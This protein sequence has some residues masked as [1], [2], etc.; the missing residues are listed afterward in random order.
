MIYA[1][2][3]SIGFLVLWAFCL[4][5][6]LRNPKLYRVFG[7]PVILVKGLWILFFATLSPFVLV[8]YFLLGFVVK[9]NDERRI[10]AHIFY[11][12]LFLLGAAVSIPSLPVE[13]PTP[14]H[15]SRASSGWQESND[16]PEKKTVPITSFIPKFHL[17]VIESRNNTQTTSTV[18]AGSHASIPMQ[19]VAIVL[20][21]NHPLLSE[22]AQ[23]LKD[24]LK[25][26]PDV[27]SVDIWPKGEN[28]PS[29]GLLPDVWIRL[30]MPKISE[31]R[32]FPTLQLNTEITMTASNEPFHSSHSYQE[33]FSRPAI[34]Y[35][36]NCDLSH[37][38][39][40]VSINSASE[41]YALATPEIGKE[42]VSALRDFLDKNKAQYGSAP[43]E[44]ERFLP[45]RISEY[46][47]PLDNLKN[48]KP[49]I[50]G[51]LPLASNIAYWEIPV[52]NDLKTDFNRMA[53]SLKQ[54]GWH[55]QSNY[56]ENETPYL[57]YAQG[58]DRLTAFLAQDLGANLENQ[59][60]SK[61]YIVKLER[62]MNSDRVKSI[63][64]QIAA[65][66][67]SVDFLLMM[68]AWFYQD[69]EMRQVYLKGLENCQETRPEILLQ[70]SYLYGAM[71]DYAKQWRS[72]HEA[73]AAEQW[74]GGE[75][76]QKNSIDNEIEK[77]QKDHSDLAVDVSWKE[78]FESLGAQEIK[79]DKEIVIERTIKL[80]EPVGG[81]RLDENGKPITA[82]AVM[83]MSADKNN[84]AP[85]VLR[86]RNQSATGGSGTMTGGNLINNTPEKYVWNCNL[87]DNNISYKVTCETGV[88][89]TFNLQLIIRLNR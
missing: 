47:V 67:C 41:K 82:C 66:G 79:G 56:G 8:E 77:F 3:L 22:I 63:L 12:L 16:V 58:D 14:V 37:T 84:L 57:R 89:D 76:S 39:K 15:V 9:P 34:D 35:N 26:I 52:E 30:E 29:G 62:G 24:S 32:L 74:I 1:W 72:L 64:R 11:A 5:H 19:R 61:T 38:S 20:G 83:E 49:S 7:L 2:A 69:E 28:P 21:L 60:Q 6:C 13:N 46:Q 36:L 50:Q 17:G 65:E 81:Y 54:A 27:K 40:T 70:K 48:I 53:E 45:E 86:V 71:G 85:Y 25:E 33:T 31:M 51:Y 68:N 55:E 43:A 42:L 10:P 44:M 4:I 75:P 80:N 73:L 88:G 59:L 78:L 18:S 23:F 87:R